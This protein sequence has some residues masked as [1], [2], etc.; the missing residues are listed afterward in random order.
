MNPIPKGLL[1][2]GIDTL[3]G[4]AALSDFFFPLGSKFFSLRV[5][6]VLR[7]VLCAWKQT[8]SHIICLAYKNGTSV[9]ENSLFRKR[10][11]FPRLFTYGQLSVFLQ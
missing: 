10:I 5:H 8:G 3:L 9:C 1:V 2:M 7:R 4:E 6:I 11:C